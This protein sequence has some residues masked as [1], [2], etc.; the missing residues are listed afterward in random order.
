[1][2]RRRQGTGQVFHEAVTTAILV[3][4]SPRTASYRGGLHHRRLAFEDVGDVHEQFQQHRRHDGGG[5]LKILEQLQEGTGV[6]ADGPGLLR[7]RGLGGLL[8][9]RH[10]SLLCT[11]PVPLV[12]PE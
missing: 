1:M 2:D 12:N 7:L 9:I 5:L 4:F 10:I 3:F 11:S 6:E 8:R